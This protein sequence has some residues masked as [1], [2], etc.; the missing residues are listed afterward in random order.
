MNWTDIAA[1]VPAADATFDASACLRAFPA[2]ERA[3]TTPQDPVYHAEGDVWTHTCM[4]VE[5]MLSSPQYQAADA[6]GRAVLFLSALLHDIAK[7]DTTVIDPITGKIGQPGHSRRGAIDVRCL[8]WRAGAPFLLREEICRLIAVHQLPF[9]ALATGKDD[10]RRAIHRLSWE[11]KLSHLVA[12]ASADMRGRVCA[13]QQKI[14]DEVE[15]FAE[16]AKEEGCLDG[17]RAFADPDARLQWAR[18]AKGHPDYPLHKTEGSAVTVLCGLPASGKDT[19]V[20]QYASNLP[21]VSFDDAKAE[22]GLRHGQNDGAAAHRVVDKAKGLLRQKA[23]FVWNAT[24]LSCQMRDKT[25]DLLYD[26]HAT[27]RI[28]YLEAS[29]GEILSRNR[30]RDSSLTNEALL[31]MLHRWEVPAPWESHE[32][33]YLVR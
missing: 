6:Q 28:V 14:L 32:L 22:L 11:L 25:L 20:R 19:W 13:D 27:V 9:F 31:R 12:L 4:V 29:P 17:P 24:H 30:R 23:A 18:H 15:L 8:L 7:A 16:L 21:V 10:P 33:D 5:A 1:L 3:K 2:L 26:Y